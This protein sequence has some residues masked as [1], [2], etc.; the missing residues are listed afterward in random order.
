V[1]EDRRTNV[2][3]FYAAGDCTGGLMQI[4]KAVADGAIAGTSVVKAFRA[5]SAVRSAP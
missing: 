2:P 4:S 3:G 1:D 5:Q